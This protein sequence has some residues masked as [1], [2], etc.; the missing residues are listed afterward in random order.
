MSASGKRLEAIPPLESDRE[1]EDF[2]AHADLS[3]YDLSGFRP[4]GFEFEK[5][6]ARINMRL[7]QSLLE[8]IKARAEKRGVPYQRYIREVLA[9]ALATD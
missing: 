1:A 8:A 5:K 6:S 9:R 7:P 3:R 2:V 4:A